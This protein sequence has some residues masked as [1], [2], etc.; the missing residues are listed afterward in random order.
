MHLYYVKSVALVGFYF[1]VLFHTLNPLPARTTAREPGKPRKL[2]NFITPSACT[3]TKVLSLHESFVPEMYHLNFIS[4][5]NAYSAS[6][7]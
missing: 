1:F 5:V 2:P 6:L 3:P 7:E 4:N